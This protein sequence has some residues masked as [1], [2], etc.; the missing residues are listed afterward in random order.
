MSKYAE[1]LNGV[2]T[3][4]I[5]TDHKFAKNSGLV[6][7]PDGYWIGDYYDGSNWYNWNPPTDAQLMEQRLTALHLSAIAQGQKQTALELALI[8]QGQC[9]TKKELEGLQ[10]V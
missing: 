3:N 9:T 4:V 8:E 6:D 5:E 2:C 10:N 1:I 7:I